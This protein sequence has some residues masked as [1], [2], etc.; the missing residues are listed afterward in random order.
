MAV[1]LPLFELRIDTGE[2]NQEI[3]ALKSLVNRS[4]VYE[5]PGIESKASQQSPP[6]TRPSPSTAESQRPSRK[7]LHSLKASPPPNESSKAVR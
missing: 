2:V 6:A 5:P 4:P 3:Q 7:K 1:R